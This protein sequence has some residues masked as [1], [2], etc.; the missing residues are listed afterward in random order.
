MSGREVIVGIALDEACLSLDELARACSA[1][2]EW[3][4]RLVEEGLF[5]AMAGPCESWRFSAAALHRARRIRRIERDFEAAP[6]LAALVADML[7][8]IDR[9][10]AE[11][12]LR[13]TP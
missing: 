11:L 1:E 10:R 7:E 4:V 13:R 2:R 9:L 12:D 3:I 6:E 5:P 8:E